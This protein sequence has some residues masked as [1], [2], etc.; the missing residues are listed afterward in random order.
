MSGSIEPIRIIGPA[1]GL[2]RSDEGLRATALRE[3]IHDSANRIAAI[4]RGLRAAQHLDAIDIV[5][6]QITQYRCAIGRTRI[7]DAN[8]INESHGLARLG[9]ANE[10]TRELPRAAFAC[11]AQARRLREC[12]AD[13]RRLLRSQIVGVDHRHRAAGAIQRLRGA[14]CRNDDRFERAAL[15]GI[16]AI[17]RPG[18]GVLTLGQSAVE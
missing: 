9:A 17:G 1:L 3:N 4:E 6:Q 16:A 11:H 12:I 14:R 5:D 7:I 13:E 10:Y 8:A 15:R 18:I 2:E